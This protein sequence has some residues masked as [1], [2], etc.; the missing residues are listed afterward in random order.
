MKALVFDAGPII[1]FA[2]NGLLELLPFLKENYGGEFYISNAVKTEVI[3][4]PL[5]TKKYGFEALRI[6][7]LLKHKHIEIHDTADY[8]HETTIITSLAN[9]I[10]SIN[11]KPLKILDLGEIDSLVLAK[12]IN[13]EA[14]VVDER[15]TRMLIENPRRLHNMLEKRFHSKV[16]VDKIKL[17]EFANHFSTIKIIRSV[18]LALIGVD[19]GFFDDMLSYQSKP[20]VVKSLLWAL[21]LNGCAISEKDI[22]CLIKFFN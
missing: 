7:K 6:A 17:K 16:I 20:E 22:G 1:S 8:S 4:K 10:F 9:S 21:K 2:L 19:K 12:N 13:A 11:G 18:E 3:D 15:T 5:Q 14:V